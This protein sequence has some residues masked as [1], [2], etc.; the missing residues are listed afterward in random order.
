MTLAI[1]LLDNNF[2]LH[3]KTQK[4]HTQKH[5]KTI[6]SSIWM[7]YTKCQNVNN[8][9]QCTKVTFVDE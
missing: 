4:Y 8:P 1:S 6:I 5:T 2:P 9:P 3:T 7:C